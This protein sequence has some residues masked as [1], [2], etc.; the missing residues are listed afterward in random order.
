MN[1]E[2]QRSESAKSRQKLDSH[3]IALQE[4]QFEVQ[5]LQREIHNCRDFHSK[6]KA[7]TV[8]SEEEFEQNAPQELRISKANILIAF[9]YA[10]CFNI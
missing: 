7:L 8:I 4:A 9:F 6:E 2:L 10:L 5:F 3:V 1:I